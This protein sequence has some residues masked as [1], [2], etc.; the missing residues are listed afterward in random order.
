MTGPSQQGFA[1]NSH[2]LSWGYAGRRHGA[3]CRHLPRAQPRL[4]TDRAPCGHGSPARAPIAQ[5]PLRGFKLAQ[6]RRL[7][8]ERRQTLPFPQRSTMSPDKH[9]VPHV[10]MSAT[11]PL[12]PYR[13]PTTPGCGRTRRA[14]ESRHAVH[15]GIDSGEATGVAFD[16]SVIAVSCASLSTAGERLV[17]RNSTHVPGVSSSPRSHSQEP[18]VVGRRTPTFHIYAHIIGVSSFATHRIGA[19]ERSLADA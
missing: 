8:L 19:N 16:S 2:T 15:R 4:Q 11:P 12:L 7:S 5:S 1:H 13:H 18:G 14:M 10:A 6:S 3:G 17:L 9:L